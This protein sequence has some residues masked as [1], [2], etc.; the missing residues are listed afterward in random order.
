MGQN[1]AAILRG[2]NGMSDL[3]QKPELRFVEVSKQERIS[4]RAIHRTRGRV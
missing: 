2:A 4:E 1:V 3:Y